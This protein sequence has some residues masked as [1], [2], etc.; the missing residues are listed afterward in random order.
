MPATIFAANDGA[1]NIE[2][3]ITDGTALRTTKITDI[4]GGAAGGNPL[5]FNATFTSQLPFAVLGGF[6]YFQATTVNGTE[7]WRSDGTAIGTTQVTELAGDIPGSMPPVPD[8]YTPTNIVVANGQLFFSGHDGPNATDFGLFKSNGT[9]AGTLQV[10]G[11]TASVINLVSVGTRVFWQTDGAT[12]TSDGGAAANLSLSG[13]GS[14][15][16]LHDVGGN[17]AFHTGVTGQTTRLNSDGTKTDMTAG[18]VSASVWQFSP[19]ANGNVWAASTQLGANT[20]YYIASGSTTVQAFQAAKLNLGGMTPGEPLSFAALGSN[21]IFVNRDDQDGNAATNT[22]RELWI[23]DG[24]N[25]GTVLLKDILPGTVPNGLPMSSNPKSLTTVGSNVFF[26]A[27]DANNIGDIGGGNNASGLDLWKTDGTLAGTVLVKHIVDARVQANGQLTLPPDFINMRAVDGILYFG[28]DTGNGYELWRSDGT[29]AGTFKVKEINT[30]SDPQQGVYDNSAQ[31]NSANIGATAIFTGANDAGGYE[32][33]ATGGTAATTGVILD[34]NPGPESSSPNA[35]VALGSNVIFAATDDTHGRELWITNGTAV[36]TTRLTD[37]NATP[38]RDGLPSFFTAAFST[39][40]VN[41]KLVFQGDDGVNGIELWATDGTP[42][43]TSMLLDL[44]PGSTSGTP[45]SG[46]PG[47]FVTVGTNAFFLGNSSLGNELYVTDGTPGGTQFV[48]DIAPG[49]TGGMPNN[50]QIQFMTSYAGKLFFAASDL[51]DTSTAFNT[52]LWMS[53]GTPG[54]TQVVKEI[55]TSPNDDPVGNPF[56]PNAFVSSLTVANGH[57]FFIA[58]DTGGFAPDRQLWVSDGTNVTTVKLSSF[59]NHSPQFLTSVGNRLYYVGTNNDPI[60]SGGVG[61]ELFTSTGG[62]PTAIDINTSNNSGFSGSSNPTNLTNVNGT[63]YFSA[64]ATQAQGQEL[65][66]ISPGAPNTPVLVEDINPTLNQGSNPTQFVASG[67]KLFFIADDGTNGAELWVSEGTAGTTQMVINLNPMA[68]Q[69]GSINSIK[70]LPGGRVQFLGNDGTNSTELYITDGTLAGTFAATALAK[71]RDS[72][73]GFFASLPIDLAA[74]PESLT[75]TPEVD[76]IDGGGG[77]DTIN[78]LASDDTLIGGPGD[79]IING[80]PGNDTMTG[81]LNNDTYTVDSASD[82]VV[83]NPG[84]GTDT[85]V[86]PLASFSLAGLPNV[87]NLT[88][89]SGSAQLL[90][91]NSADNVLTGSSP[92]GDTLVGS[93]GNDTLNGGTGADFMTGGIG[94]DNYQVDSS[95]DQISELSGEGT[96]AVISSATYALSANIENLTMTG[97]GDIAGYGN[98]LANII[99]GNTGNNVLDGMGG[100]DTLSGGVG[101][102]SYFADSSF[103]VVIEVAAAGTDV[104]YAAA[105]YTLGANIEQLILQGTGDFVATGNAL[106]N[107]IQGNTGHNVLNGMGGGDTMIGGVGNDAYFVDSMA[108]T[109]SENAAEGSDAVY[110]SLSYGLTANVENLYLQGVGDFSATGNALNNFI[111]GNT[112]NN[113]LNGL[114]GGDTMLGG[115]GNDAYFV[116]NAVDTVTENAAEGTDAVYASLSHTLAANVEHLYLQGVGDFSGTGNALVNFLQG[117]T[118]NN[119]LN[120]MSG[121]DTMIGGAGSDAYFVDNAGDVVT[122]NAAEGTDAVYASASHTL[123]AN[124]EQLILQGTGDFSGSGNGLNNF[125]QGNTGHNVINGLGGADT[126]V[127]GAGNDAY[128]VDHAGD[129]VTENA[130]EGTDAV[131]ASVSHMLAANVEQLILQGVGDFS[132]TGNALNNFIQGN[133]GHNVLNGLGGADTMVGGIGNDAY[134]VDHAGDVVTEN[135]A[136]GTDAVYSTITYALTATV[137]NLY[138]QG[139]GNI[140]GVGNSLSNFIQGN[141]GNNTFNGSFGADTLE[142]NGGDDIF[143][144]N[145]GQANGD[146]IIDFNGNAAAA[147]DF[148]QFVGYGAGASLVNLNATQWQIIYNGGADQDTITFSNAAALHGSDFAFI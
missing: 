70:A 117:N 106:N 2:L 119:V 35:F 26:Q 121:G 97:V 96:D 86:T 110:A 1:N 56:K 115:A 48:K 144:F 82:V 142:G 84:E 89:S 148:L 134:F 19:Q 102:D 69:G 133:T 129:V 14:G 12:F 24:T 105:S 64:F 116:D 54:G 88:G 139:T 32:L 58:A 40:V 83:E 41:N 6:A 100:A 131:Y 141:S 85:I 34:I 46:G 5:N 108:D 72:S 132:G 13:P 10:T 125:I 104:V 145:A 22:G 50:P 76:F 126:M 147:G 30:T 53:D 127:G 17:F 42:G 62:A 91:G 11:S 44:F 94:N 29:A 107:F 136:E 55:N 87:E 81:G 101:N 137:E 9:S 93:V 51:A 138:L 124:V 73:P 45:N 25:A 118:G 21:L 52:E 103:D 122:E 33:W 112:G 80:G 16:S 57:L 63:L 59:A 27:S 114:G 99:V 113:V 77:G 74:G 79:D 140:A 71:P 135:A 120:G 68:G 20:L 7:L 75:G 28:A 8:G 98:A 31:F 60:A 23:S 47:Q 90:T 123:A 130:A 146:V 66:R 43:G 36:G 18:E 3:W 61:T 95:F 65:W 111:Q 39:G 78:G 67:N 128:F 38:F 109:V 49:T 15:G 143:V 92:A 4:V 37:I